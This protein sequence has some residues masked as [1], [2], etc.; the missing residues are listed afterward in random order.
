M[1][2][3]NAVN[4]DATNVTFRNYWHLVT[5]VNITK[6]A[7]WQHYILDPAVSR[8]ILLTNIA[9][10]LDGCKVRTFSYI[11]PAAGLH[12]CWAC[13]VC[14]SDIV[15]GKRFALIRQ[16][17]K[18]KL[19]WSECRPKRAPMTFYCVFSKLFYDLAHSRDCNMTIGINRLRIKN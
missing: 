12:S 18:M 7:E 11:Y 9:L 1:N 3:V 14:I 13:T 4:I 15:V 16:T 19:K 10:K 2:D 17:T 8:Y 5:A 6:T